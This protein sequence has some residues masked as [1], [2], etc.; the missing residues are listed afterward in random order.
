MKIS[1]VSAFSHRHF[2]ETTHRAATGIRDVNASGCHWDGGCWAPIS[3]HNRTW[4]SGECH[5]KG[6]KQCWTRFSRCLQLAQ[7]HR[8]QLE[9]GHHPN[10]GTGTLCLAREWPLSLAGVPRKD[11][12]NP[13][14]TKGSW[15]FV[16]EK[17]V[18]SAH[19][20]P[21]CWQMPLRD[22]FLGRQ[23]ELLVTSHTAAP[24]VGETCSLSQMPGC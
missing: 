14:E 12:D 5:T 15:A 17:Q 19:G 9:N 18:V 23:H 4:E 13:R 20:L 21:A 10:T 2:K 6:L 7:C 3:S 24:Q 16:G 1:L 22:A 11:K 8:L